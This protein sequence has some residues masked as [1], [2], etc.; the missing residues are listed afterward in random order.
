MD[1]AKLLA[2]AGKLDD[3]SYLVGYAVEL[4]L[5]ARFCTR[6]G[7]G[8]FPDDRNEAK[9]RGA[10]GI[11][12]HDLTQLLTLTDD[13]VIETAN[14]YTIDWERVTHWSVEQRYRP[15]G[16]AQRNHVTAQIAESHKVCFQLVLFEIVDGLLAIERE[17]ASTKGPF[18]LFVFGDRI[19]QQGGW[20][21]LVAAW[22]LAPD[23]QGKLR[24]IATAIHTRLDPDLAAMIV[25]LQS[26]SPTDEVVR[27]FHQ[28]PRC[29]HAAHY[30][31]SH[32]VVLGHFMPP[33]Y[34]I[35]NM[36]RSP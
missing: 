13:I 19:T 29:E 15:V 26:R 9:R 5:K 12:T 32:N 7:W 2:E 27:R 21:L 34:I 4:S 35:T 17:L 31:A 3:A 24:E 14:L 20:E 11:L 33:A 25:T 30:A 23:V 28:Y 18:D 6:R 16:A 1:S 10:P 22:W 36:M 8:D